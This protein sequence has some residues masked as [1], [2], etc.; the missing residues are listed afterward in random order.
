MRDFFKTELENL[1]IKTGLLQHQKI[2]S[3]P[4]SKDKFKQLFD[5]LEIECAKFPFMPDKD[6]QAWI[7]ERVMTD[8]DFQGFNPKI[9]NKWLREVYIRYIP[10][11]SD[12][13]ET[14]DESKV[15]APERADYWIEQWKISLAKIGNREPRLDGIKDTR[16]QQ[17]KDNFGKLACTHPLWLPWSDTE[18]RC[19]DCGEIR[20]TLPEFVSLKSRDEEHQSEK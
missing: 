4:E 19:N 17:M 16:I 6:K 3:M 20:P 5:L 14:I 7:L 8:G 10:N 18:Q 9:V 1:Y 15:V 11:Q 13:V 12:Y 2:S